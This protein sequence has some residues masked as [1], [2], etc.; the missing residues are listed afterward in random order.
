MNRETKDTVTSPA[1]VF[2]IDSRADIY[3]AKG[4]F[5]DYLDVITMKRSLEILDKHHVRYVI[6]PPDSPLT[7]LVKNVPGWKVVYSDKVTTITKRVEAIAPS[8]SAGV[9]EAKPAAP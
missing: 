3:E 1:Q 7:Y 6:M 4:I 9:V 8:A 5:R 2:F